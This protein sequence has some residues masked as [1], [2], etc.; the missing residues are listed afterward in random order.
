MFFTYVYEFVLNIVPVNHS[1][2]MVVLNQ[3]DE[4]LVTRDFT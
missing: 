1:F 3:S 4:V 2:K